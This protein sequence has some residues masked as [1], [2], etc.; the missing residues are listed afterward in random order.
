LNWLRNQYSTFITGSRG[1]QPSIGARI[2]LDN[3]GKGS[4]IYLK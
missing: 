3:S 4:T 1:S 2:A